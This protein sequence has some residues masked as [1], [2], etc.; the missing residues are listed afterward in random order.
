M[1]TNTLGKLGTCQ[2]GGMW[3]G[4][5]IIRRRGGVIV[6]RDGYDVKMRNVTVYRA[7]KIKINRD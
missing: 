4:Q 1:V 6:V 7:N 3:G 2:A 5:A